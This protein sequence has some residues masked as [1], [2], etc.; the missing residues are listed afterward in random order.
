M[1]TKVFLL[2]A[3][4]LAFMLP[5]TFAAPSHSPR[6]INGTSLASTRDGYWWHGG[7]EEL[8]ATHSA[9]KMC[10]YEHPEVDPMIQDELQPMIEHNY[11]LLKNGSKPHY[12][13]RG[14]S[15]ARSASFRRAGQRAYRFSS[16]QSSIPV[17][18]HVECRAGNCKK[19]LTDTESLFLRSSTAVCRAPT[20]PTLRSVTRWLP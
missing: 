2:S 14:V 16:C 19:G 8:L 15:L 6:S 10:A 18:F 9:R 3:I 13:K 7:D 1:L 12:T 4:G 11:A 20:S 17:I 5:S